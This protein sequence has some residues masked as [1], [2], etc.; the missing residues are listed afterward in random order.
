MPPC[1]F[2]IRFD[3]RF[4]CGVSSTGVYCRPICRVKFHKEGNCILINQH[5]A[6]YVEKEQNNS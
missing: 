1:R 5:Y 6:I 4:F 3:G 2:V